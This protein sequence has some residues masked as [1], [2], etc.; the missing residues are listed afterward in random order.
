M[1]SLGKGNDL[2]EAR[3][4]L[5]SWKCLCVL[6]DTGAHR[7]SGVL[8]DLLSLNETKGIKIPLQEKFLPRFQPVS[9]PP[10][11][12]LRWFQSHKKIW[13]YFESEALR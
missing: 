13:L 9:F 11:G 5:E 3:D 8:S 1:I 12:D 7:D 2:H 6:P 4:V 10:C